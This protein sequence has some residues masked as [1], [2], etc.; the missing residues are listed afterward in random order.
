MLRFDHKE[1]DVRYYAHIYNI[2]VQTGK[3]Y[4]IIQE[5][6]DFSASFKSN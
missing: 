4:I 6:T 1:G 5:L 2:A 3:L